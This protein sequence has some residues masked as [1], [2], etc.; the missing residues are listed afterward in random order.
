LRQELR[1]VVR[2]PLLETTRRRELL[3]EQ[4]LADR[5]A[6]DP[7]LLALVSDSGPVST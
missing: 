1:R 7:D 2:G 5:I 6:D 4:R 3:E